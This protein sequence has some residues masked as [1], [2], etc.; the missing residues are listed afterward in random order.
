MSQAGDR[1]TTCRGLVYH[2]R[3]GGRCTTCRGQVAKCHI[4]AL[5]AGGRTPHAGGRCA[6]CWRENCL[7]ISVVFIFFFLCE[8]STDNIGDAK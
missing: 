7:R 8:I 2:R 4:Q 1:Y 5:Y 6:T 3:G